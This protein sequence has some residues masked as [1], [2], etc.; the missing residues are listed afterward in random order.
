MP[1][2]GFPL[3]TPY[4]PFTASV[5][6][7]DLAPSHM[8]TQLAAPP[9]PSI[10]DIDNPLAQIYNQILRFVS[11]HIKDIMEIAEKISRNKVPKEKISTSGIISTEDTTQGFQ[12]L[13]YVVWEEIANAI[14]NDIGDV[15][16][17]AGRPDELRK[18]G[19]V[20]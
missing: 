10:E 4:T 13:A 14:I 5:S 8:S 15:V 3:R 7:Q 9:I 19:K 17:T 18:V 2:T 11:R 6:Y 12:I 20:R 1:S 16:F